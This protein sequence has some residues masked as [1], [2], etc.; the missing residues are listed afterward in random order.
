MSVGYEAP[1]IRV[2]FSH[3]D[4]LMAKG[5]IGDFEVA[6]ADGKFVAAT[7]RI[8]VINGQSTVIANAPLVEAPKYIRYGWKPFT[9]SYLYNSAGLPLGTFT[10]ESDAEMQAK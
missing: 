3:A 6:G 9:R 8:E 5:E 2:Y 1:S 10:S 4:G 7:A